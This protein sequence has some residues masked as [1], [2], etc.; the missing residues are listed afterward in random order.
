MAVGNGHRYAVTAIFH[1][2][3][4]NLLDHNSPTMGVNGQCTPKPVW[5]TSGTF[6][7]EILFYFNEKLPHYPLIKKVLKISQTLSKHT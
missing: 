5:L 2:M 4:V 3:R 6:L 1:S 7:I